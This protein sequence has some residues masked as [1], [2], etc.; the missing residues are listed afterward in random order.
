M[1]QCSVTKTYLNDNQ[2]ETQLFPDA[3]APELLL[4]D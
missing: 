1:R 4:L 2:I 3:Q